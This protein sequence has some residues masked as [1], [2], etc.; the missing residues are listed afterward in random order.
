MTEHA[1]EPEPRHA[2]AD[3]PPPGGLK[4]VVELRLEAGS[5]EDLAA[6]FKAARALAFRQA[7]DCAETT[8]RAGPQGPP[9]SLWRGETAPGHSLDVKTICDRKR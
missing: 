9:V 8:T 3:P 2:A 4:F 7:D 1:E 5:L 6:A